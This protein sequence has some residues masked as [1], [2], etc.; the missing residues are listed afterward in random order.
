MSRHGSVIRIEAENL[1]EYRR[2]HAAVRPGVLQ[3]LTACHIRNYSIYHRNGLLFAY[4]EYAG[5][6]YDADMAGMAADPATQEWWSACKPL[7][8]PLEDR[9]P[10]EWRA[11]LDEI[12]HLD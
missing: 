10:A 9:G 2:L 4:F 8:Q 1:A 5:D 7:Q 11:E 6:D 3:T 12:F